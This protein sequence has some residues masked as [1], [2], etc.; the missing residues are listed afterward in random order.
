MRAAPMRPSPPL[1]QIAVGVG[2]LLLLGALAVAWQAGVLRP[3]CST[4]LANRPEAG[5]LPPGATMIRQDGYGDGHGAIGLDGGDPGGLFLVALGPGRARWDFSMPL[6]DET[7][8]DAVVEFYGSRLPAQG[9]TRAPDPMPND[10]TWKLDD[11]TFSL[12][13]PHALGNPGRAQSLV[14]WT[15]S[16]EVTETVGGE[17]VEP[18]ECNWD[19]KETSSGHLA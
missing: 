6:V 12:N 14:S 19:G 7:T 1:W 10:W 16:W 18:H 9:W 2:L 17:R 4:Y 11:L 13:G 15:R 5:M 3:G 8:T